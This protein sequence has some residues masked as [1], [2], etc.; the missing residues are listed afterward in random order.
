MQSAEGHGRSDR[1][2]RVQVDLAGRYCFAVEFRD[3][4]CDV[5]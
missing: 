4:S 3:V 5:S 1:A 2:A